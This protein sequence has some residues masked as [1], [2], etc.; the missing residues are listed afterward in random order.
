MAQSGDRFLQVSSTVF[1]VL[2]WVTLALQAVMG[3]ILVIGGGEAVPVGAIELPARVVG[4]L[5]LVAALIY[6]FLFT[7][8]SKVT[9]LLLDVHAH[10]SKSCAS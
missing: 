5:N 10:V 6:W 9:R 7:F 2:A 4:L 8:I 3:L 1:K